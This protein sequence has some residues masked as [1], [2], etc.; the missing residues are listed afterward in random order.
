MKNEEAVAVLTLQ[1]N[2]VIFE[3]RAALGKEENRPLSHLFHHSNSLFLTG[4]LEANSN[5]RRQIIP[6]LCI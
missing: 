1:T 4:W 2:Y 3:K 5:M 6:T